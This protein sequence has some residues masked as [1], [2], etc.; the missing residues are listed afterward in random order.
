ME[1]SKKY[2]Q[3]ILNYLPGAVILGVGLFALNASVVVSEQH[4]TMM[5]MH[6]HTHFHEGNPD[7]YASIEG[8][9]EHND[10]WLYWSVWVLGLTGFVL[11]LMNADRLR[12]VKDAN[13]KKEESL[14]LLEKQLEDIKK[15]DLEKRELQDQLHQAQ[16]LEAVGRLAGGIA[17]DFN[18]IL[19]AMNGY[20]E[21]L[22]DDL[23]SET[24]QRGFAKNILKAGQQARELVDKMLAFSRRDR[25]ETQQM[26]VS[27]SIEETVSMLNA[28]L[29]KSVEL[30]TD[31]RDEDYIIHGCPTLISQAIMNLCVNAKDAM[32]GEKGTLSISL[33]RAD[34]SKFRDIECNDDLPAIDDLP[35]VSIEN[36]SPTH[37]RLNLGKIAHDHDYQCL[38]I[39]DDGSGMSRAIM[40]NIFE[41]FFTTKSVDKGTGLGLAMVHGVVI[42]HRGAMQINSTI[43]E[44]TRF[45]ILLPTL[46]LLQ[47]PLEEVVVPDDWHAVGRILIV[48]DQDDVLIMM[49]TMMERMGYE[50]E[51]CNGAIAALEILREHP[52]YFSVVITDQNMPKMTGIE[53][54][55]RVAIDH[56]HIPFVV[57]TGYSLEAMRDLMTEHP[58]IRAILKK[59]ID[60]KKL[61]EAVQVAALER[62]FAA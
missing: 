7:Q 36:V 6:G 55:E 1:Q 26:R 51:D 62:Q 46:G 38:S 23:A 53:L 27:D 50:V 11:I 43:G 59:P 21:F 12:Q 61:G 2:I 44:G 60:R 15:S 37:T 52:D 20:A 8:M 16:K 29:P 31:I 9:V 32:D 30:E 13:T 18:N 28:S 54:I 45:D 4:A 57:V 14:R 56:P 49:K 3:N 58:S 10:D 33:K 22:I 47:K 41:P 34:M 19:A 39:S 25:N 24:P 40:E 42:S 5:E 35:L 17:H 48:D